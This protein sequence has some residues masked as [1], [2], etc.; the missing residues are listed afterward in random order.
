MDNLILAAS[1]IA[2]AVLFVCWLALPASTPPR[3]DLPAAVSPGTLAQRRA[4]TLAAA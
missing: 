4:R 2:F 3:T 1:L